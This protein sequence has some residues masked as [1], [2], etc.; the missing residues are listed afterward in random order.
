MKI[1]FTAKPVVEALVL[2]DNQRRARLRNL[3]KIECRAR[4]PLA[5]VGG[6]PSLAHSLQDLREWSGDIWA[7][8]STWGYLHDHGIEATFFNIDPMTE[9]ARLAK[10][11]RH[12]ILSTTCCPELFDVV[13]QVEV[14]EVED[15]VICTSSA[16]SAAHVALTMGY[17]EISYFG[18]DSSFVLETHVNK[19]EAAWEAI[20]FVKCGPNT[21]VTKPQ[22]LMQAEMIAGLIRAAPHVF[23]DRSAGLL[24]AMVD[25]PDYDITHW[26]KAMRDMVEGKRMWMIHG[27][28]G[29]ISVKGPQE[30]YE[31]EQL[32]FSPC[33]TPREA[34]EAEDFL[35]AMEK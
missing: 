19:N 4:P 25:D 28:L 11:A 6:G 15:H 13:P 35:S 30:R 12:A 7:C 27:D 10:G 22:L 18:C 32:G 2:R 16:G 9:Q 5:V 29:M 1:N 14:F 34:E 8:A 20:I 33:L 31:M 21:Y 17:K 24:S 23:K 3:P 26:N